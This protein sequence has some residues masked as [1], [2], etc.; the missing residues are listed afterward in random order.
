MKCWVQLNCTR[1]LLSVKHQIYWWS[2]WETK[3]KSF[4]EWQREFHGKSLLNSNIQWKHTSMRGKVNNK[5]KREPFLK[6]CEVIFLSACPFERTLVCGSLALLSRCNA[7]ESQPHGVFYLRMKLDLH[8]LKE[9]AVDI[10][11]FMVVLIF[12]KK[13]KFD[14]HWLGN[15]WHSE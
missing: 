2:L 15:V 9:N 13:C 14:L 6:G 7:K 5:G 10:L 11:C 12:L 1:D 3:T 4:R 8:F